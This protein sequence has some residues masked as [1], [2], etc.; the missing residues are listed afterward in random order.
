M[1][2]SPLRLIKHSLEFVPK[3]DI[4]RVPNRARGI[5]VLYKYQRRSG[6]Y[7][8]VYVGMARGERSGMAG[9][10]LSHRRNKAHL[11]THFSVFEVW[12]NIRTEEVEELEGL[13]RHLYR[14][15]SRANSLNKQRS[16]KPLDRVRRAS[17]GVWERGRTS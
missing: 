3:A 17:E 10:L 1:S 16:Y 6:S 13:F 9:R 12:D 15:D 5:Y 8:V 4:R 2:I 7:N 11:W 14:Q